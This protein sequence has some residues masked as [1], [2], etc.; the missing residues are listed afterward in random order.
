MALGVKVN[1]SPNDHTTWRP[2]RMARFDGA[3][4]VFFG[5]VIAI[6]PGN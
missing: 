6:L 4:W 2:I 5:D 1:I 3:N